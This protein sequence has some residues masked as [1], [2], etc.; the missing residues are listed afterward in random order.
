MARVPVNSLHSV[1]QLIDTFSI[2]Q[3]ILGFNV[4]KLPTTTQTCLPSSRF[5]QYFHHIY[6]SPH[7][8]TSQGPSTFYLLPGPK[9]SAAHFRFLTAAAPMMFP[10]SVSLKFDQRSKTTLSKTRNLLKRLG[11]TL[12]WKLQPAAPVSRSGPEVSRAG[13]WMCSGRG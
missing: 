6:W 2:F 1:I 5:Q 11:Y 3:V 7:W 13:K 10:K 9:A 8:Q 4:A 12:L